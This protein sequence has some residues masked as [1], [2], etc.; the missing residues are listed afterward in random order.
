MWKLIQSLFRVRDRSRGADQHPSVARA[1]SDLQ[2]TASEPESQ[3]IGLSFAPRTPIVAEAAYHC[4]RDRAIAGS[5]RLHTDP[6]KDG[7]ILVILSPAGEQFG[8]VE[9]TQVAAIR[10]LLERGNAAG[11]YR[12]DDEYAPFYC[13]TCKAVYCGECWTCYATYDRTGW[14]DETRGI[15]P[16]GHERRLVD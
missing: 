3:L 1:E 13:P 9:E 6:D 15:C 8:P 2:T 10:E 4:S 11:L 16:N 12:L 7:L 5:L 14:Y